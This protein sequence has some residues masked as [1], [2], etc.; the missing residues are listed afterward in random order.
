MPKHIADNLGATFQLVDEMLA[1]SVVP[2]K[3]KDGLNRTS[4]FIFASS[5]L[6]LSQ[7]VDGFDD[8]LTA[9]ALQSVPEL[10]GLEC[11]GSDLLDAILVASTHM[12]RCASRIWQANIQG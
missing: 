12:H 2:D 7:K 4:E 9:I 3:G 5:P 1:A 6:H 11:S 10:S 8:T